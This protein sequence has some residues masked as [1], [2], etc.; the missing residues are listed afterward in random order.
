MCFASSLLPWTLLCKTMCPESVFSHSQILTDLVYSFLHSHFSNLSVSVWKSWT[1]IVWSEFIWRDIHESHWARPNKR[2]RVR[3]GVSVFKYDL[4]PSSQADVPLYGCF[5]SRLL[6]ITHDNPLHSSTPLS[7]CH[8]ASSSPPHMPSSQS[9]TQDCMSEAC[10]GSG[11]S[12]GLK[13]CC[14]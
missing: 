3:T 14:C 13:G 5:P 9:V 8:W 7:P 12:E 10:M 6:N 2:E 11:Q 4:S 1:T